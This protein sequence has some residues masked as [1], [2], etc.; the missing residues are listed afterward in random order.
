[1]KIRTLG[2]A[3]WGALL[4]SALPTLGAPL[5]SCVPAGAEFDIGWPG[6]LTQRPGYKGSHL[7][8]I[9]RNDHL[10]TLIDPY[11]QRMLLYLGVIKPQAAVI[12]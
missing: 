3:A 11:I 10:P 5:A 2:L 7:Q 1:M 9:F 8:A 12:G 4:M 6:S